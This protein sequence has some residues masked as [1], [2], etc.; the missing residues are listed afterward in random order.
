[1]DIKPTRVRNSAS[2]TLKGK[3]SDLMSFKPISE[4][5]SIPVI[6]PEDLLRVL[7]DLADRKP[8]VQKA[9]DIVLALRD[10]WHETQFQWFLRSFLLPKRVDYG[11]RGQ[12]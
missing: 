4:L 6:E 8:R 9:I 12:G 3:N 5:A 7:I 1:M 10:R 2:R 11:Q